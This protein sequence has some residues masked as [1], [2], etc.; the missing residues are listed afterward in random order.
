VGITGQESL[1]ANASK[2][3]TNIA[4]FADKVELDVRD[5]RR[6]ITLDLFAEVTKR[7]PVD[8]GRLRSSW[9]VSDGKPSAYLAPVG[10]KGSGPIEAQFYL[11]FDISYVTNNLPYAIPIE[12]GHSKKRPQ[13]MARVSVAVIAASI[14]F[15]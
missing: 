4:K 12:Y 6:K 5:V 15:D 9:A 10:T 11:P 8:T 13:G 3:A 2:F 1:M 7:T 14:E